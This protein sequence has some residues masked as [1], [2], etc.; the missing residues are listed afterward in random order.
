MLLALILLLKIVKSSG[1]SGLFPASSNSISWQSTSFTTNKLASYANTK[2][3]RVQEICP[4]CS[5]FGKSD[6][7]GDIDQGSVGDCYFLA[8]I[9]SVAEVD[10]RFKK[11]FVNQKNNAAGLFA[12][13]VFI[14]GAPTVVVVDSLIPIK[15]S[16]TPLFATIGT[17][18]SYWG[19]LIEKAWAKVNG[20]YEKIGSGYNNEG[21]EFLTNAPS[22]RISM[23]LLKADT[24]WNLVKDAD[25]SNFVMNVDTPSNP[26]GDIALCQFNLPCQHTFSLISVVVI[27]AADNSQINLYRIRNPW[28]K[29]SKFNGKFND[30]ASIWKTVGL[31]NKTYANQAGVV[32]AED[33][34]IM[35]TSDEMIQ[36]F[37]SITISYVNDTWITS[38]YDKLND[39]VMSN[40]VPSNY[41]FSIN[42]TT[43]MYIRLVPYN[44]RMYSLDCKTVN[45]KIILR[46]KDPVTLKQIA[47]SSN[48]EHTNYGLNFSESGLAAGNYLLEAY[49]TWAAGATIQQKVITI[50]KNITNNLTKTNDTQAINTPTAA[51]K[52]SPP[53]IVQVVYSFTGNLTLDF[54]KMR[55]SSSFTISNDINGYLYGQYVQIIKY[56][57][58]S[59]RYEII[60][61]ES[62]E[63][64]CQIP[65][66]S[67]PKE[68]GFAVLL[69]IGA[70]F[71]KSYSASSVQ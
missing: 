68:C 44:S 14:K 54:V 26:L 25:N 49:V 46:L 27:K 51:N 36:A 21:V 17:D 50:D 63:C 62:L 38:W 18:Q 6:F 30:T 67:Y 23:T 43:N 29:D 45:S 1:D 47:F 16:K 11:I 22:K 10:A 35:M 66:N 4:N 57:N 40:V 33:G 8:G 7:L 19:A 53:D 61:T 59:S 37:S 39:R 24:L 48:N 41:Y 34:V 56:N 15:T 2:W 5:L 31:D 69:P 55:N 12:F 9:T 64:M 60:T 65:V 32:I 58:G 52:T 42:Q 3:L 28:K 13:N 70:P 20:N 71:T